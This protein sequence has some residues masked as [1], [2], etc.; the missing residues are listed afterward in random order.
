[1]ALHR[2]APNSRQMARAMCMAVTCTLATAA[3]QANHRT[4]MLEDGPSMLK[5]PSAMLAELKVLTALE[6]LSRLI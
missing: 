5:N 4:N 3:V 6:K 2:L 1:M